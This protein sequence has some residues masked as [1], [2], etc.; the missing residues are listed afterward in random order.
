MKLKRL[1]FLMAVPLVAAMG[2]KPDGEADQRY[3]RGEVPA[4]RAEA[5]A[6]AAPE[7][8]A[9]TIRTRRGAEVVEIEIPCTN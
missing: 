7:K 5:P 1:I 3:V 2:G 6:P 8:Q 9:C 4:A